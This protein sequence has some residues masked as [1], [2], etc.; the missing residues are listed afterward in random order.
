MGFLLKVPPTQSLTHLSVLQ[1]SH[2]ASNSGLVT[3]K[4]GV[5]TQNWAGV[6]YSTVSDLIH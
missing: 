6:V 5:S 3:R 2:G 1:N 4:A